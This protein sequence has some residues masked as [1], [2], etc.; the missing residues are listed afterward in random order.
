MNVYVYIAAAMVLAGVSVY[1]YLWRKDK[2]DAAPPPP[3]QDAPPP[4][5]PSDHFADRDFPGAEMARSRWLITTA[6]SGCA[7][8]TVAHVGIVTHSPQLPS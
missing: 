8:T 3:L 7:C 6:G 1:L 2:A 5:P 4:P